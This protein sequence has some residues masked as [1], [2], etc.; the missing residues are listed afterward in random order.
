V[1]DV[2]Y[3]PIV[4]G[5]HLSISTFCP[6]TGAELTG[7]A[8]SHTLALM[9]NT[10]L[11]PGVNRRA[12]VCVLVLGVLCLPSLS[13]AQDA[14]PDETLEEIPDWEWPIE[15][16]APLRTFFEREDV[17]AVLDGVERP[18]GVATRDINGLAADLG[19][20]VEQVFR[21]VQR[22]IRYEPYVGSIRGAV[23]TLRAG[24]GNA[25]D[26][27]LL[28]G[29]LL[30]AN[31]HRVR[32]A[33]GRLDWASAV[34]LT[35]E[36]REQRPARG[37][38][39]L[40]QVE[41][42]SDHW[43]VEVRE[44]G[45][46]V[47]ADASFSGTALGDEMAR[48]RETVTEVPA[49]LVAMVRLELTAGGRRLGGLQLPVADV[50]GTSVQVL[51]ARPVEEVLLAEEAVEG[52]TPATDQESMAADASREATDDESLETD[53]LD[54]TPVLEAL[55][56]L[57][58]G[59][60]ELE[61]RAA[62]K[63]IRAL[64]IGRGRLGLVRLDIDIEIPPGRHV[65][66]VLPFGDDPFGRLSVLVAGGAVRPSAYVDRLTGLYAGLEQLVAVEMGALEAW[67]VRPQGD[68]DEEET[69]DVIELAVLAVAPA[70]DTPVDPDA[71]VEPLVHPAVALHV[72]ALRAWEV[73]ADQGLDVIALA[74][75]GAADQLRASVPIQR[76]DIRLVGL[77][78]QPATREVEG[79]ITAWISDPA[80]VGGALV[81]QRAP[82]QVA[83]GL[84]QS[85][86]AGQ[87]L[88]R[89]ADRPPI[90]AYDLTL[91]AVGSG[92]RLS[93]FRRGDSPS[94]WPAAAVRFATADLD[95]GRTVVG[96]QRPLRRGDSELLAWWSMDST[97][98]M[99]AGRVHQP[100]GVAQ[101]AVPIGAAVDRASLDSTLASLHDL[102][103]AMRWLLTLAD[104]DD[105]VLRGLVPGACA[106][107][108]L[109]ADLLR[110]GAPAD[111]VPP[112][113][114]AFCQPTG[115]S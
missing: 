101:A 94:S 93:W 85:A 55:P 77:H 56:T 71:E 68:E 95:A 33:R 72:E 64:P 115:A 30:R 23:G 24:G 46:W 79:G 88:N 37:D 41:A 21:H 112:A 2:Y 76:A 29:A 12:L 52:A 39:W 4:L 73:F 57:P 67:R 60:V 8:G 114:A 59:P 51:L 34:L 1:D 40:R 75:L 14:E 89:V 103:V 74:L 36:T 81:E 61:I 25:I 9:L 106:A 20:G 83:L 78:Y 38:P 107:T 31:G 91:R 28:L 66:A 96:P 90:T 70:P 65:R 110:A 84:L 48:R 108:P 45:R 63:V 26:Q 11:C 42:A 100:I 10:L 53:P 97:S 19:V 109:V 86:V 62:G 111:F 105:D 58:P 82:T 18:G 98:G 87:V 49:R 69:A 50:F 54:P 15:A 43:W 80:R 7:P 35:G 27:S 92:S 44:G 47:A 99:T 113:F 22:R 13:T 16:E 17:E 104:E 6:S 32:L 102:H 5:D 3:A